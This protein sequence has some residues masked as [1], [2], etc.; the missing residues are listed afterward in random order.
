M[1]VYD[2]ERVDGY[3]L[4][5]TD[6]AG[7]LHR[8]A[9]MSDGERKHVPGLMAQRSTIILAGLVIAES[10]MDYYSI[11]EIT[12]SERDLLEGVFYKQAFYDSCR[13]YKP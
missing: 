1:D 12:V 2:P 11:D 10:Y 7:C 4:S 9:S 8:L 5:K 6:L 3:V 13:I